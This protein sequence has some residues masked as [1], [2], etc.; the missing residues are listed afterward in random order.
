[1]TAVPLIL[2][3]LQTDMLPWWVLVALPNCVYLVCSSLVNKSSGRQH[4]TLVLLNNTCPY[5]LL[6]R[7]CHIIGAQWLYNEWMNKCPLLG[8]SLVVQWLG[9]HA[10][11][12]GAMGSIPSQGT[13]I[14]HATWYD[15]KIK[16]K[17]SHFHCGSSGLWMNVT[18][19]R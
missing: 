11:T 2:S 12:A 16:K 1:M 10:C 9:F 7:A 5:H 15:Q 14:T 19:S 17:K 8:T 18:L 13:K 6:Q 3:H 4:P